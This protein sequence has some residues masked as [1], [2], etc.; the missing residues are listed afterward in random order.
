MCDL[1]ITPND[2]IVFKKNVK[3]HVN[4]NLNATLEK[5]LPQCVLHTQLFFTMCKAAEKKV[6]HIE[7]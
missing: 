7:S 2:S 5:I 3:T 4:K 6:D 1:E